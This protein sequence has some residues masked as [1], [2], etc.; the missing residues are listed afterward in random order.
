[1]ERVKRWLGL[2]KPESWAGKRVIF[3]GCSQGLGRE[4]VLYLAKQGANLLLVSRS[5]NALK[6]LSKECLA[7]GAPTVHIHP[8]DLSSPASS[9]TLY[10]TATK[11]FI[12]IDAVFLN[13]LNVCPPTFA[14]V[15]TDEEIRLAI[16][17]NLTS[18][19]HL[20]RDAL[21]FLEETG[22]MLVYSASASTQLPL[23]GLSLYRAVKSAMEAYLSSLHQELTLLSS[24]LTLTS[25][26]IGGVQTESFHRGIGSIAKS[27]NALIK[28]PE[29]AIKS[30]A[31]PVS[32]GKFLVDSGAK[33]VRYAYG[34]DYVAASSGEV[35]H[36]LPS[37]AGWVARSLPIISQ[38]VYRKVREALGEARR[39]LSDS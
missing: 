27:Q 37:V 32:A 11:H 38:E 19:I 4:A 17:L 28:F 12:Q 22:G 8:A 2:Q 26:I 24:P 16:D 10:R 34:P 30:A 14:A 13:H 9:T 18:M 36:Y 33:R 5:E 1:M 21:P 29:F 23:P 20:V 31:S 15:N 25:C 7:L 6:E 3:C 35:L 39:R